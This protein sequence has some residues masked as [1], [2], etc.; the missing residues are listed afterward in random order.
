MTVVTNILA[1]QTGSHR[2]GEE[3]HMGLEVVLPAHGSQHAS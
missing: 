2:K 3:R 1:T